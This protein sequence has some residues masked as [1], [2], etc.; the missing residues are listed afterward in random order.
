MAQEPL[1]LNQLLQE[2]TP[3]PTEHLSVLNAL[4]HLERT[5]FQTDLPVEERQRFYAIKVKLEKRASALA[6]DKGYLVSTRLM[7]ETLS[8]APLGEEDFST[9]K[10]EL[11][12]QG[13]DLK[14][15][16]L[17]EA[18]LTRISNHLEQELTALS[19]TLESGDAVE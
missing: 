3:L 10:T 13:E 4:S 1:S 6:M 19:N 8:Q 15:R 17:L 2:N 12:L 18:P 11:V 7:L 14:N 16:P 5:L 9:L